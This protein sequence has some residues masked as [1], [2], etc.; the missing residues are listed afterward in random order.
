M[1]AAHFASPTMYTMR[2]VGSTC[3]NPLKRIPLVNV[4]TVPLTPIPSASIVMATAVKPGFC[5]KRRCF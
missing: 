3:G 1:P 4:K 5:R 2:F